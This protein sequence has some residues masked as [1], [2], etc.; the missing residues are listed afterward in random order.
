MK[1]E[2]DAAARIFDLESLRAAD[3]PLAK[4]VTRAIFLVFAAVV[5]ALEVLPPPA[6]YTSNTLAADS[7][8]GAFA[9]LSLWAF[10][11][12]APGPVRIRVGPSTS[13]LE[14]QSG[15]VRE[16]DFRRSGVRLKAQVYPD[17]LP[18]PLHYILGG[19]PYWNPISREA[20][21]ELLTKARDLGLQVSEQDLGSDSRWGVTPKSKRVLISGSHSAAVDYSAR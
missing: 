7:V 13:L 18:P 10:F 12:L 4:R 19:L 2:A 5:V 3:Y 1:A 17:D 9:V 21:E 20:F 6:G 14:Y 16:I 15:R 11:A 8:G